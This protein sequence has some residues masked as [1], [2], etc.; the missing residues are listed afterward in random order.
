MS[1]HPVVRKSAQL[2]GIFDL[3]GGSL[4]IDI[5]GRKFGG[6][7]VQSR[8]DRCAERLVKIELMMR[9]LG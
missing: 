1:W 5:S 7:V 9:R 3:L 2:T 4:G 6:G 8:S